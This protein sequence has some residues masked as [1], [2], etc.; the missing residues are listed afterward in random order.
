MHEL[1]LCEGIVEATLRRAKGRRVTAV[2][3]RVGGHP[4]DAEVVNQGFRM[5]AAGTVAA[6]AT[7]EL[8]MEPMTVRC[9]GCGAVSDADTSPGMAVCPR[10][11]GVDVEVTGDDRAVLESVSVAASGEGG[12]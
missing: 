4:V 10:C 1:G 12:Q 6:D 8:V 7:V 11:G 3:V 2:R 5:A 9:H